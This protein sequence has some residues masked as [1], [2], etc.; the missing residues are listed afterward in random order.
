[1]IGTPKRVAPS[2]FR[3]LK[4]AALARHGQAG[5]VELEVDDSTLHTDHRGV[6]S[7]VGAQLRKDVLDSALDGLLADRELIGNLLV[8][9]AGGNQPQDVDFPRGQCLIGGMFGKFE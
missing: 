8:G 7:V 9:I 3:V 4:P 5:G 6:G 1:M 2:L